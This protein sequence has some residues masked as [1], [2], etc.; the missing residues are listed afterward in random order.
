MRK[1]ILLTAITLCFGFLGYRQ[2]IVQPEMNSKG[3]F[4]LPKK[5]PFELTRKDEGQP[6]TQDEITAFTVRITGMWK[7]MDY[8]NWVLRTS[9]GVH[10]STGMPDYAAWWHDVEAVK[11]GGLVTFRHMK[12]GGGHNIMI[13]TSE[14]LSAAAPGYLLTGDKAMGKVTEQYSKAITATMK[15]MVWDKNDPL[16]YIMARN[17]A[18]HNHTYTIEGGRKKAVD[19]SNWRTPDQNWNANRIH[20]PHNPYWGDIYVTNMRSKDDVPHIYRA[21]GWLPFVVQSG[22]DKNVVN[23]AREAWEYLQGFTR[24]IVDSGYHIRT[25]DEKG[26]PYIP[27]EDLASFVDYENASTR[28]ECSAKLTSALLGYGKNMG[29]DCKNGDGGMY[30]LVAPKIHYYN[31]KI[32]HG[33]HMTA[34]LHSLIA[35]ENQAA[36]DLLAGLMDRMDKMMTGEGHKKGKFHPRWKS[37]LAV[38]LVQAAGVGMP[39]TSEQVRLVQSEYDKAVERYK[40][41]TRWDL[42][43]SSVPDGTYSPDG[44]YLPNDEGFV[45]PEELAFFLEYCYTPFRNP[46]G[47]SPVDCEIVKNPKRWGKG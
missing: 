41:F 45:R 15:G 4:V 43:D 24:D 33:F 20:F 18:V 27:E 47:K 39:L 1:V 14:V 6:P 25:K 30:D 13:P 28:A 37:D 29:N 19:Y 44:G 34:V 3:K 35:G 16:K 46:S 5:L 17:I 23:A 11:E 36:H 12:S 7:K 38:F 32:I 9:H 42:W 40:D 21:A 10:A 8:F 22:K 2:D 31:Y 26:K